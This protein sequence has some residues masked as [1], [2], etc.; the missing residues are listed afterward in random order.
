MQ[1]QQRLH[2]CLALSH[3]RRRRSQLRQPR[4]GQMLDEPP[5]ALHVHPPRRRVLLLR[6]SLRY[7]ASSLTEP[8][9]GGNNQLAAAP[10]LGERS[11]YNACVEHA[12]LAT[13][14]QQGL[15]V[16]PCAIAAAHPLLPLLRRRWRLPR[17][18]CTCTGARHRCARARCGC[19]LAWMQLSLLS[20]NA[21]VKCCWGL[22]TWLIKCTEG[23][24]SG[25][26]VVL[27]PSLHRR[28]S[29]ATSRAPTCS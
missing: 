10:N 16:V 5:S 19:P 14:H 26:Q 11:D 29:T 4:A 12:A 23:P 21:A 9:A 6:L 15:Q 17:G 2:C 28:S 18:C 1:A 7:A 25:R 20:L 3:L 13:A 22:L 8:R 27:L 24:L